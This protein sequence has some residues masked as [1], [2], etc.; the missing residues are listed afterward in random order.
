MHPS[1][2][3]NPSPFLS[4]FAGKHLAGFFGSDDVIHGKAVM[5]L[6]DGAMIIRDYINGLLVAERKG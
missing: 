6:D 1:V 5:I 4:S 3:N 2:P